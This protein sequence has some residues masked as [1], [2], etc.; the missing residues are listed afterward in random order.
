MNPN[1][2][3]MDKGNTQESSLADADQINSGTAKDLTFMQ[4]KQECLLEPA[5]IFLDDHILDIKFSPTANVIGLTQVTGEVR[6]YSYENE[7]TT[8]QLY[9][10]YHTDSCRALE[11]SHDGNIIYTASKDQSIAAITNG[12]MAG[13][14]MDAHSAPIYSLLHVQDGNIIATGDDD[15]MVRVWD[16]RVAHRGK[17]HAVCMEFAE[18][19]GTVMDLKFNAKENMLLSCASDGMLAV[20]DTRKSQL[21]AMSDCF[22]E[23]LN[24]MTI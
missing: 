16:L 18:H 12:R 6:L 9:F 15:G 20:Y 7:K 23:D 21:Y 19:E 3:L 14:I 24:A 4:R 17:K 1:T 10:N 2:D 8:E 13:R 22:E 11:F 5:D